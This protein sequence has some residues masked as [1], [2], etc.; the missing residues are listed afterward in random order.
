MRLTQKVSI[1]CSERKKKGCEI[2]K[3][4]KI[5]LVLSYPKTHVITYLF[6][7]IEFFL[8]ILWY[9][10]HIIRS[11]SVTLTIRGRNSEIFVDMKLDTVFF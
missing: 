10:L 2:F 3:G 9:P 7:T 4:E 6:E 11:G 5:N 8:F 1:F